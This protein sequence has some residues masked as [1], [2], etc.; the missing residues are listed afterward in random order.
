[1]PQIIA[2]NASSK[3]VGTL[4][5]TAD[6]VSIL[7]QDGVHFPAISRANDYLVVTMLSRTTGL[8]EIARV[9]THRA[10]SSLLI[11][12]QRGIEGTSPLSFTDG[13]L[14]EIRPTAAF[15]NGFVS[16]V[17]LQEQAGNYEEDTGTANRYVVALTPEL[18][19][20]TEGLTL[21]FKAANANTL[22]STLNVNGLGAK[23]LRKNVSEELVDGDIL[24]G[25]IISVVYDGTN[26]QILGAYGNSPRFRVITLDEQSAA[27]A[28]GNDQL[29]VYAKDDGN[30]KTSLFARENND[31]L[32]LPFPTGTRLVC[33]NTAAPIGWTRVND[34]IYNGAMIQM[35]TT[36]TSSQVP[37]AGGGTDNPISHDHD[38]S[39]AGH[40]LTAAEIPEHSHDSA[41]WFHDRGLDTSAEW[42]FGLRDTGE[43]NRKIAQI[44]DGS[45]YDSNN[46]NMVPLTG[47]AGE[48]EA[49]DHGDT[50]EAEWRPKYINAMVIERD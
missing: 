32:Q 47:P 5:A 29:A 20:Y 14:I 15:F 25:Q 7:Q 13:D 2:N 17:S 38:H 19:T 45:F 6:R 30:G 11:F 9:S 4:T 12:G 31:E 24:T 42:N 8:M 10:A 46:T 43:N 35:V 44:N 18:L 49:H 22:S 33:F 34:A 41:M 37:G 36:A 3:I 16:Q 48:G 21:R 23:D 28:I 27:P 1:M 39:T 40:V 50:G 26:F